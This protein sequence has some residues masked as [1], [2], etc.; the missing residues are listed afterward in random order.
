MNQAIV[1]EPNKAPYEIE[2]PTGEGESL[3]KLQELVGGY[4]EGV[5]VPGFHSAIALVNEEGKLR[6]LSTNLLA[7]M[8]LMPPHTDYIAGTAIII[9]FNPKT[10]ETSRKLPAQL[11]QRLKPLI[12]ERTP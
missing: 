8:I 11:W 2:L 7:T 4:I 6:G 10:G 5:D 1:I 3:N 9:G 12:K